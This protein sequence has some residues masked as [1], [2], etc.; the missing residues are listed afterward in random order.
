MP[1][2]GKLTQFRVNTCESRKNGLGD[3][4][5]KNYESYYVSSAPGYTYSTPLRPDGSHQT[6]AGSNRHRG[7]C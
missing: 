6:T 3:A 1:E 2:L 5:R 7:H 4:G